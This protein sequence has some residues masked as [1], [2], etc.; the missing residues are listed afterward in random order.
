MKGGVPL[1]FCDSKGTPWHTPFLQP[2]F[3]AFFSIGW[4]AR[5]TP[6]DEKELFAETFQEMLEAELETTLGY[7][8][9]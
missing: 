4:A 2:C 6:S 3:I 8:K 5:E 7:A 9:T 1:R